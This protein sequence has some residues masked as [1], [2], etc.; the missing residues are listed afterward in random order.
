MS[1]EVRLRSHGLCDTAIAP[2]ERRALEAFAEKMVSG[3]C[4]LGA[5][6]SY[7]QL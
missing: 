2:S 4:P 3:A 6:G 7:S 1:A 5:S